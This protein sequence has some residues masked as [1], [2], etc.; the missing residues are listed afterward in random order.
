MLIYIKSFISR[1]IMIVCRLFPMNKD[2]VVFKSD[3]GQQCT[4]SPLVLFKAMRQLYPNHDYVW[5]VTDVSQTIEGARIVKHGS[6]KEIYEL[7]TSRIWIDNKR[8]GL[9]TVKRNNQ[10]YVQTWH[11]PIALKKV[12][13]DIEDKLHP[14]YVKS[15]KHD[16]KVCDYFLSSCKWATN[17]YRNSFWYDGEILE[18]GVPRSDI[19]YQDHSSIKKSIYEFYGLDDQ[20]KLV[21]YAPTFRDIDSLSCY[22]IDMD[23]LV[24]TLS[25]KFGGKWKVILRLHPNLL[26]DQA[27]LVYNENVLN[28]NKINDIN[29]LIVSSEIL[30][31]DYSSCMFDAMEA[32]K[33]VLLYA[34]DIDN[35]RNERGF[36]FD[37]NELPFPIGENN[38]SFINLIADFN[39]DAYN[40]DVQVFKNQLHLFNNANS[41]FNLSNFLLGNK[42]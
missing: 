8:K 19:F 36:Y 22:D 11:G 4:D 12:E 31:T 38:D 7:A 1:L 34:T 41:S 30:I 5:I 10:I 33:I 29:D 32:G 14:Y 20:T 25:V 24:H 3:R 26:N 28:G 16:S 9:W 2:K 42:K 40:H 39:V 13:K 21:L 23:R 17:F 15:A 18:L 27:N 35:Y 6:I 37:L